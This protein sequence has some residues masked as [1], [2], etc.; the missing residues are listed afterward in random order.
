MESRLLF[1]FLDKMRRFTGDFHIL[2]SLGI[3]VVMG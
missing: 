1:G 3:A 2:G